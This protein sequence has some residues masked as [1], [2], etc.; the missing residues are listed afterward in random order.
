MWE[1]E[2]RVEE[3]L[4][5]DPTDK[6]AFFKE[7]ACHTRLKRNTRKESQESKNCIEN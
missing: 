5:A 2:F 7:L 4:G 6:M 3:A 1:R